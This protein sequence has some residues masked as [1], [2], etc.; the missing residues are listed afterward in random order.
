MS[1]VG[2][3]NPVV[4]LEAMTLDELGAYTTREA[5]LAE[6]HAARAIEHAIACGEALLLAKSQCHYGEFQAWVEQHCPLDYRT[7]TLWMRIAYYKDEIPSGVSTVP[8]AK[9]FLQGR[10]AYSTPSL[11]PRWVDEA[12]ALRSAGVT[13]RE[14]CEELGMSKTAVVKQLYPQTK[15]SARVSDA[16]R[17]NRRTV[18]ERAARI[19]AEAARRKE[20]ARLAAQR[21]DAT[22]KLYSLVR[23]ALALAEADRKSVV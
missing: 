8:L 1:T 20:T 6:A 11:P 12:R 14:I 21:D 17:R 23:Q 18:A 4:N 7:A 10:P 5:N 16:R 15:Q 22:S 19:T 3:A 13:L 2:R 9:Q